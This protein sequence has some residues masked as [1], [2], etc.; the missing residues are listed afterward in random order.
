MPTE[1]EFR[2]ELERDGFTV[3]EVTWAPGKDNPTHTHDF[4]AR[5]LCVEGSFTFETPDGPKTRNPGEVMY[6]T[7]GTPHAER[8]GA[9]GARL[10]VGRSWA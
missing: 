9:Q 4:S 8:V 6:V 2:A 10:V 1:A 7:A 5:L 3:S